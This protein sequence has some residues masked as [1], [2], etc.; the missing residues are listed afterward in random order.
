MMRVSSSSNPTP[1]SAL[2][3]RSRASATLKLIRPGA[4]TPTSFSLIPAR[5]ASRWPPITAESLLSGSSTSRVHMSTPG[6]RT[7][8]LRIKG[9]LLL[10]MPH[11]IADD[12][13]NYF[14]QSL[15]L[16]RHQ[17]AR[18]WEL[19]TA[20]DLAALWVRQGRSADAQ[21]LLQPLFEQFTEGSD[22]ADVKAAE[23]L[24]AKLG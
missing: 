6:G 11:S 5:S 18:A 23:Y 17:G 19:R 7:R 14:T 4:M 3:A 9:N 1:R 16:G 24:L 2:S 8:P 10:S 12:A 21:S 22:M 15:A 13:E 20:T